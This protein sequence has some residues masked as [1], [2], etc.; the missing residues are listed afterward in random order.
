VSATEAAA[1]GTGAG[2]E[3]S[4]KAREARRTS[5]TTAAAAATSTTTAEP[6]S[7]GECAVVTTAGG[8]A[9][10]TGTAVDVGGAVV[11]AVAGAADGVGVDPVVRAVAGVADGVGVGEVLSCGRVVVGRFSDDVS[12]LVGTA[13]LDRAVGVSDDDVAS[14]PCSST[15]A[16]AVGSPGPEQ[17]TIPASSAGSTQAAANAATPICCSTRWWLHRCTSATLPG[18]R[19]HHGVGLPS[20]FVAIR[21]LTWIGLGPEQRRCACF[22]H[23][24]RTK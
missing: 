10:R 19:R 20:G 7:S 6:I 22:A 9:G 15:A 14:C 11:E 13:V 3:G 4:A 23:D 16:A 12:G 2:P 8:V 17:A 21:P 1:A 24:R 18:G 5:S